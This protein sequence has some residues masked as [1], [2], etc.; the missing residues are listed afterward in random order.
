MSDPTFDHEYSPLHSPHIKGKY[1]KRVVDEDGIPDESLVV[2]ECTICGA[3]FQRK[4][5]S[6]LMRTH[7]NNFAAAHFHRTMNDPPVKT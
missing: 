2:A 4:C 3:K 1:Q 7:I 6:G 5:A